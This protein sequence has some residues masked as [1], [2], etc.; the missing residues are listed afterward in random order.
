MD[1]FR[2][3]IIDDEKIVCDMARMP[4]KKT[5]ILSRPS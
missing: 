4:L 2:I 3:M 1:A 5:A